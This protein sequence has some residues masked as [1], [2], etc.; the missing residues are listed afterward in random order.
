[1]AKKI[2]III[3]A[4]SKST[5]F[6]NKPMA[7]IC[8]Q[9]MIS[10]VWENA[11]RDLNI[12][13]VWVATDSQEIK[14]EIEARGGNA[15]IVDSDCLTGTDRVAE[16][17]KILGYDIVINI[18]GDEPL[19]ESS[20]LDLALE[21]FKKSNADAINCMALIQSIN[22]FKNTNI[23]K[24]ITDDRDYLIY[25]SRSPI[26]LNKE[27]ITD[28]SNAYRQVC[29]YVFSKKAL[30]F[31]GENKT[32]CHLESIEDI[33]ILRLIENHLTVKMIRVESKSIAVDTP[34][35]LQRV[36]SFLNQD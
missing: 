35:D 28:I 6:P 3:P 34:D 5:R 2:G 33:E 36:I 32:K 31:Y 29:T 30:E 18:Q 9:T 19:L 14:A 8:G 17:N 15:L 1:M 23:P 26:P 12:E 22:D 10:R 4:R 20:I 21:A 25:I 24:V 13:D 11:C 27:K 7:D 16:A